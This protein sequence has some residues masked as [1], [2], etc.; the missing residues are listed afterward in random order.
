MTVDATVKKLTGRWRRRAMLAGG[1]L[2]VVG[3]V[4]GVP[5]LLSMRA[6]RLFFRDLPGLHP[7]RALDRSGPVSAINIALVGLD[8]Q[9]EPGAD[10]K[11]RVAAVQ[12]DPCR[13]LFGRW[14]EGGLPVAFF[15]DFNCPNCRVLERVLTDHVQ[16]HPGTLHIV[17]HELPLLGAASVTASKAVL[18][19]DRQG[20]Y[21]KMHD[22]LMRT[23][24]VTDLALIGTIAQEA[25]LDA[26]RLLADMQTPD[27][28]DALANSKAIASIFGFFGTPARVIARTVFLGAISAADVAQ[29]I[30]AEQAL[31]PLDCANG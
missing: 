1:A 3:W 28:E 2:A 19:A 8:Q 21:D 17:R 27:I 18:A 30:A 13:A 16:A 9:A 5:R 6:S 22:R 25:G 29:I 14:P 7:F 31:P 12:A 23:R 10:H 15:S 26:K 11:Q 20:G 4:V 24:L